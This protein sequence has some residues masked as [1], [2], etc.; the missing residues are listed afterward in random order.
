MHLRNS[1][2]YFGQILLQNIHSQIEKSKNINMFKWKKSRIIS[3]L[4]LS[5]DQIFSNASIFLSKQGRSGLFVT[6]LVTIF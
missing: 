2:M 5:N 4:F 3:N 6:M 1:K